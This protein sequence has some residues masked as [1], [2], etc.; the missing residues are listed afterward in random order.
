MKPVRRL[1]I[2]PARGGSKR[3]PNKNIR[4]FCGRPMLVHILETARRS[5]LFAAI[6]VST[7]SEV[8]GNVAAQA[9]F[10]PQFPRPRELADDHTP[11]IPVLRWTAMEFVRRGQEFDEIW[12]LMACA[13]LLRPHHLLEMAASMESLGADCRALMGVMPFPAPVQRGFLRDANGKLIPVAP[14][15]F[16]TRSQDLPVT[17]HDAG[18]VDIYRMPFLTES[19]DDD[20]SSKFHGHPLPRS[21]AVDID[22]E[23]DWAFAE[24]LYRGLN[25]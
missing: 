14:E 17:Y 3:I 10:A 13:P 15:F 9:G 2:I 25:P 8:I 21:A 23:D 5:G 20:W 24:A 18:V 19:G 16:A 11:L 1:A 4:D 22:N 6:H 7:D 12:L